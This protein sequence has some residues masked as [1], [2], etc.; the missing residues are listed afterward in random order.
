MTFACNYCKKSF[1]V[2]KIDKRRVYKFCSF[3]CWKE[4]RKITKKEPNCKC[5]VCE[6]KFYK[7][8]SAIKN[9]EGKFC[10]RECKFQDQRL[11]IEV[12]GESYNDRQL[13]RQSSTYRAWRQKAKQLKGNRCERCGIKDRSFCKC[14]GNRVF[15]HVHHIKPFSVY[16]ELRFDPTN[17]SVLCSKCHLGL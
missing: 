5:L 8:P 16:S 4:Y 2:S 12:R 3:L 13:I 7:K 1:E 15:L 9:G 10:S 14:C 11:G 17:A 6:K